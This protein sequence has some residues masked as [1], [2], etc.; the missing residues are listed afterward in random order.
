MIQILKIG[1]FSSLQFS[2]TLPGLAY[3]ITVPAKWFAQCR[4]T[5]DDVRNSFV[6]NPPATKNMKNDFESVIDFWFADPVR[7]KWWDKD[8]VFDCEISQRFSALH[9]K[10]VRGELSSWR[11]NPLG[12]LAEII[13][14]DQFSRN[15]F[16][17]Q[18]GAF[19]H[20]QQARQLTYLA[21]KLGA[22][23]ALTAEQRAFLYMPLMHSES[24]ADHAEA[25]RLFSSHPDLN[26][27][28]GFELR[29]KAIIDRFGRYP[30]RN[31]ILGRPS[32][33]EEEAFLQQPGSAF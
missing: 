22:D 30:H 23:L 18:P 2:A 6:L 33:A 19:A 29:H 4:K 21:V 8:D 27:S 28:L 5:S 16:R 31:T 9:Q 24:V 7:K 3:L 14:L 10:A 20:D 25:V 15:M 17:D 32:T 1:D 26:S 13:L 12:R 11:A